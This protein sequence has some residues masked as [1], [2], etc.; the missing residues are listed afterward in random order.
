MF[1]TVFIYRRT[2]VEFIKYALILQLLER[3][4]YWMQ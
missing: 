3:S 1:K 2:T 4:G